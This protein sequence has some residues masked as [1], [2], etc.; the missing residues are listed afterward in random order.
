MSDPHNIVIVQPEDE[1]KYL[2]AEHQA[3][4]V[5]VRFSCPTPRPRV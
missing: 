4:A 5:Q 2:R 3:Q 1:R